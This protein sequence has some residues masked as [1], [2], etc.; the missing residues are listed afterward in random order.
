MYSA[1]IVADHSTE[2]TPFVRSGIGAKGKTELRGFMPKIIED[3]AGLHS[4]NFSNG[5]DLDYLVKIFREIH[6]D[7]DIAALTR[8][9]RPGAS[10]EDW[11]AMLASRSDG[12]DYIVDCS[13]NNNANWNLPVI[14][15]VRSIQR[16]RTII[17]AHLGISAASKIGCYSLRIE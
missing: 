4:R 14:R 16:S 10:A 12:C 5:I 2:R 6:Y 9:A 11:R 8:N 7:S 17:E 1:G 15:C 3:Y 13:R